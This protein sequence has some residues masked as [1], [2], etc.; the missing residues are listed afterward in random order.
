[1]LFECLIVAPWTRPVM[2]QWATLQLQEDLREYIWGLGHGVFFFFFK[3]LERCYMKLH[4]FC[5]SEKCY[6]DWQLNK[7]WFFAHS[8]T[9]FESE[10]YNLV[11]HDFEVS[12]IEI[13]IIKQ[14]AHNSLLCV[15]LNFEDIQKNYFKKVCLKVQIFF[16]FYIHA[17]FVLF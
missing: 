7:A 10:R 11:F 8:A 9:A 4:Q 2:T 15:M 12:W 1:M 13:K 17:R 3:A 16:F 14:G 6:F 5:R